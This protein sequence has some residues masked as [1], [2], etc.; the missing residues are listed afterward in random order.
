MAEQEVIKHTKKIFKILGDKNSSFGQKLKD[1]VLEVII[2]V[3]AVS[4]SIWFHNWSEHKTEQKTTRTFLL[5]LKGDIQAD[6]IE[7]ED[8]LKTYND[9]KLLYTYLNSLDRNK[10]P[11]IDS[12]KKALT[13]INSNTFLRAHKSRFNGFLSAGKIMSIENDS[14][15]Q[16]IL[17]YYQEVLP[18][19]QTSEEIWLSQNRLLITYL[20]DN[21]KDFEN[22][23]D[24]F[25]VLITPKGKYLTKSLIPWQQ[26]LDRYNMISFEG[27]KIILIINKLYLN[28]K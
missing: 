7:T 9:Y 6:I 28:T 3:F 27:N 19:L 13:Y 12:L 10:K 20:T 16:N 22:D 17:N 15:T 1:F 25:Q 23:M 21:A 5:G 8:I 18:A 26:L 4:L 24:K 14:L 11:N 2:I